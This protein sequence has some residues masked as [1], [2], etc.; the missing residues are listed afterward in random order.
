MSPRLAAV[1]VSALLASLAHAAGDAASG[2]ALYE[3]RCGGCHSVDENRVGPAHRGVFGR[4][5]GTREGFGYSKA[6]QQSSIVWGEASLDAWLADPERFI[7]GQAMN[8]QV[9]D[10]QA[11]ADI[12]AYLRTLE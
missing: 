2:Q 5:A 4:R 8:V 1:A 6:L 10:A 12:V 9:S 11:R 7:P 3:A